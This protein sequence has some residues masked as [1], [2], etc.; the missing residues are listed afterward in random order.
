MVE[1][2]A[3]LLCAAVDGTSSHCFLEAGDSMSESE[4]DSGSEHGRLLVIGLSVL[5]TI[6][7][8]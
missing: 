7:V 5:L 8:I 1:G 3:G 4:S 6:Q 2:R